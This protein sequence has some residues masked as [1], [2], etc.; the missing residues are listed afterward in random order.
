MVMRPVTA[1]T[2]SVCSP[3]PAKCRVWRDDVVSLRAAVDAA[4]ATGAVDAAGAAGAVEAVAAAGAV[5]AAAASRPAAAVVAMLAVPAARVISTPSVRVRVE[6][7]MPPPD[8]RCPRPR[9]RARLRW[10]L[11]PAIAGEAPPA[12]RG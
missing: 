11:S 9:G 5:G 10:R 1:R 2:S 4:G 12:L 7:F 8:N 3:E 6:R